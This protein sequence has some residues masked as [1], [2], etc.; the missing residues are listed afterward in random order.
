MRYHPLLLLFLS[1]LWLVC[2]CIENA[3]ATEPGPRSIIAVLISEYETENRQLWK[4][5]HKKN[6]SALIHISRVHKEFFNKTS[7]T[8]SGIFN[9][10][11]IPESFNL[12][13]EAS[14]IDLAVETCYSLLEES[15]KSRF[16]NATQMIEYSREFFRRGKDFYDSSLA[17]YT[18]LS[19]AG[20]NEV[21]L[22]EIISK[23]C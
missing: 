9:T 11:F 2:L 10:A 8:E 22:S 3:T 14:L 19:W 17:T 18:M 4:M 5:V 23:I 16:F 20:I 13:Q 1:L 7:D 12:H 21:S 6:A 15:E